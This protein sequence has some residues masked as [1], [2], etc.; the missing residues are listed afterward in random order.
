M[1]E[2]NKSIRFTLIIS[3]TFLL[4][5]RLRPI[6]DRNVNDIGNLIVFS[7]LGILF[8]IIIF[9]I[10]HELFKIFSEFNEIKYKGLIPIVILLVSLLDSFYNPLNIDLDR[11]YGKVIFRACY[12]GTQN[13]ATLKL[14]ENNRFDLHWTG[15]FY[16][17]YWSGSYHINS[18]TLY[19]NNE[20]KE[21]LPMGEILYMDNM[22]K[23][24]K[25]ISNENDSI[26]IN[27]TFYYGYCKGLN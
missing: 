14:R 11:L 9:K 20:K 13:Q 25:Q 27:Y 23:E 5:I 6:I 21:S 12:E 17:S 10:I 4:I 18:D 24:L 7:C 8:L 22:K 1:N 3:L 15:I 19:L 2:T 26:N 16:S